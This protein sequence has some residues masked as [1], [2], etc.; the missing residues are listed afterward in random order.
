MNCQICLEAY[1]IANRLPKNLSCGHTFCDRC[2]KKIGSSYDIE[3]PKCRKK[4][5]NNLPICYAIY[6]Y[7]LLE[8]KADLD[9][10]CKV[11]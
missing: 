5:K 7:L 4:S 2:L 9:E 6:E 3:C 1:N 10:C 11:F 8:N